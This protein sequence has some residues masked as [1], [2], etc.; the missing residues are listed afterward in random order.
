MDKKNTVEEQEYRGIGVLVSHQDVHNRYFLTR[1]LI[2]TVHV[3]CDPGEEWLASVA[4]EEMEN[5]F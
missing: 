4:R 3:S 5:G 2:G 1:E